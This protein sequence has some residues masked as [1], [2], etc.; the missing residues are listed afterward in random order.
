MTAIYLFKLNV[1]NYP[2]SYNVYDSIGDYY[3]AKGDKANAE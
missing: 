2:E 3:D 1:I